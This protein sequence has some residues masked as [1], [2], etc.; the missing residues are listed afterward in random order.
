MAGEF[1]RTPTIAIAGKVGAGASVPVFDAYAKGDGPQVIC[2]P[3]LSPSGVVVVEVEG[4][5][6]E[7][8]YSAG[9]LL[10][11]SRNGHDSVP[12]DVIGHRCVCK[13]EED[14][15]WVKQVKAGDEP[16]LF[17]LI[18][19]NPGANNIWNA[20]LSWIERVNSDGSYEHWPEWALET[21][22]T[23][24]Q[25]HI[26]KV[27]LVAIYTVQRRGDSLTKLCEALIRDGVWYPKQ[28]KTDTG[29]PIPLHSE[30]LAMVEEHQEWM[31]ERNRVDPSLQILK[32]SRRAPWGSGFGASWKNELVRLKL[33][34][35]EP[36]LTFH[37]RRTTN[38]TLIANAVA[39]S[40][41]LYGGIER[42]RSMFGHLSK[43]MSEHYARHA[44]TEQ[45]NTESV[46]LLPDFGKPAAQSEKL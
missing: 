21:L 8:V 39:K 19:L 18:S 12:S 6:V 24:G 5:S 7:P 34:A 1:E 23:E 33:H 45:T 35:V 40:P 36:R 31:R 44:I 43:R 2:P 4:D 32:S 11:Y 30:V 13:D 29:V 27:A 10:F 37:G 9:D 16:G 14:M 42:V 20:R 46:L 25:P 3:G 22:F 15:G 28:R 38:A 26:S 41:E 17:H